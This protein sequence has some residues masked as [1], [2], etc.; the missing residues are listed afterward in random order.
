VEHGVGADHL[1][2]SLHKI[3]FY[4]KAL[5]W[6]SVIPLWPPPACKPYPIA[7]LLHAHC[8]IYAPPPPPPFYAIHHTIL[9]T[10]MSCKSQF[11]L[12]KILFYF[13]AFVHESII[14]FLPHHLHCPHYCNAIARLLR[15]IR[16]PPPTDPMCHAQ[17]HIGNG[18]IV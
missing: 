16:R 18:N 13:E 1:L 9:V 17:Y 2:H 3:L 12:Y 4:S 6:E 14:I 15:N 10:A 5:L 8:A 7:I 11:G